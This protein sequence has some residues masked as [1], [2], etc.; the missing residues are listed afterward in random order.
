MNLR[1]QITCIQKLR[2]LFI[3]FLLAARG[4]GCQRAIEFENIRLLLPRPTVTGGF[5]A[6][7]SV[8]FGQFFVE[9]GHVVLTLQESGFSVPEIIIY[10]FGII[11]CDPPNNL[12]NLLM[13]LRIPHGLLRPIFLIFCICF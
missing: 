13:Y 3:W 7:T 12:I 10:F 8:H 4:K 2:V 6:T 1:H 11:L 9:S 5:H